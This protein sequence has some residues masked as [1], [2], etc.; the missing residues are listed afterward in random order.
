[1]ACIEED[2][3]NHQISGIARVQSEQSMN[4]KWLKYIQKLAFNFIPPGSSVA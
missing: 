2:S 1:M 4:M 3:L